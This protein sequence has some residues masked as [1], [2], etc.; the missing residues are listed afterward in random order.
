MLD[1]HTSLRDAVLGHSIRGLK[2]TATFALS[3]RDR[4]NWLTRAVQLARDSPHFV[5]F[6]SVQ[7]GASCRFWSV[8]I[9]Y[10]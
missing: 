10:R 1:L 6:R 7:P 2:P 8:S 3:L 5:H 4:K 9:A